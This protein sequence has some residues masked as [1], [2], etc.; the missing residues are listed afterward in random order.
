MLPAIAVLF[1]VLGMRALR[2]GVIGTIVGWPLALFLAGSIFVDVTRN[3]PSVL[4]R[5]N[6]QSEIDPVAH[7]R[8]RIRHRYAV[9]MG[10][11]LL[12]RIAT[13]VLLARWFLF[14]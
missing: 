5:P 6:P 12:V 7:V 13:V 8:N 14:G 4:L 11:S 9:F 2:L 1:L 10:V 3:A